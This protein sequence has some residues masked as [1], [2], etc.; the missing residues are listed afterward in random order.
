MGRLFIFAVGGTGARVLRSLT[1]LLASGLKL[2]DCDLVVPVLVDP[3]TQ[4]GDV[5]RTVDLLKRYARLHQ[6]LHQGS[7]G[8]GEGFF[9]QPLATLAQLNTAGAEGLR[10]SFVYD[11]GGISQ[12]FKDYVHYNDASVETQGL[13][14]LLFTPDSMAASLDVGF[15][16]SPNVGSVVLNSLMQSKEMRYFAQSLNADDRVFFV[17]SI[18]GGTGAA[19]FPL[20]VRNLRDPESG[21]PQ[22]QVRASVPAG[23]LVLLPYFKLQ[24]P[25]A[26]EKAAGQDFIDSNSFITKTKT[27][28]SYYAD[29]LQGV[30]ALYYLGDQAGQPLPNNP[31]RAAQRNQAHLLEMLGALAIPHF[32]AQPASQLDRQHPAYHEFGLKGDETT[33]DFS[34]FSPALRQEVAKPLIRLH[35]F[36]RY[37]QNH[38]NEDRSAAFF[39]DGKLGNHLPASA[40]LLADLNDMLTEYE[41]WLGELGQNERHFA[42]LRLGETD[43]NKMV[44][45][46]EIKTGFIS[47]IGN[48]LSEKVLRVELN[49]A[50]KN[51]RLDNP[52]TPQVL[53][54]IVQAFDK[55]TNVAVDT[56]L[57]YQ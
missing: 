19:G 43:F 24:Q 35:Y 27:A 23:A 39:A 56:K 29:H 49:N 10:D 13:L 55:A 53:R 22:P 51:S 37:F 8:R 44:T 47:F 2:P 7:A 21:L 33:V 26:Q 50:V 34:Q 46:K 52:D 3:D 4:N 1:M 42:G 41:Q 11:F 25:S 57:Q 38:L 18:F 28:L 31:G 54:W 5:T 30:E 17:S 6:G 9:A 16:G 48:S 45:D 36:A 32:L 14:D 12:S 20:L 15:R 40:G